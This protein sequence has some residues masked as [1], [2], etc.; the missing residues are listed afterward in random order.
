[1]SSPTAK[2]FKDMI[3]AAEDDIAALQDQIDNTPPPSQEFIHRLH[4][5][6]HMRRS[7]IDK[8]KTAIAELT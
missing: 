2:L 7:D 5:L 4:D 8:L 1:M 3:R 6:Q